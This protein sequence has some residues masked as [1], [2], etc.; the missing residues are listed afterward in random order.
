[1]FQGNLLSLKDCGAVSA[2]VAIGVGGPVASDVVIDTGRPTGTNVVTGTDFSAAA[3]VV[4]GADSSAV[5]DSVLGTG[6]LAAAESAREHHFGTVTSRSG[7]W[8]SRPCSRP[9]EVRSIWVRPKAY[10]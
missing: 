5:A 4:I 3:D 7:C 2:K 1:L 8:I 6:G 9:V 10:M